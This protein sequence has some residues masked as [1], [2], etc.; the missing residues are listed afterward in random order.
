MTGLRREAM[1]RSVL[2]LMPE[3]PAVE[4]RYLFGTGPFL[5]LAREFHSNFVTHDERRYRFT[6]EWF[7]A[8]PRLAL[9]GPTLGW[10][11]QAIRSMTAALAPGYLERIELPL[12]LISAGQD[13]LI[14]SG[15]HGPVAA[16][17]G[18]GEVLAIAGAR[19]EVMMETDDLRALFWEA[20]DRL[21]KTVTGSMTVTQVLVIAGAFIVAGIAK[22]AIG[23]GLPPIALAL[24]SFAVPLEDALALMVVPSMATNI[25]QA[26]YGRGFLKL[27][28]R[29]W[30]MAVASV[31]AL[32]VRRGCLRPARLATGHGLGRRDP[33][34][35]TRRW[36][37][38]PGGRRC[39]A[40]PSAGPI[41]WSGWRAARSPASPASPPCRS[42]PTC[43]RSTSTG[44]TW[45]RRWASCSCSSSARSPWPW[46]SRAPSISPTSWARV[47]AIVPTFLGVWLGQ[48]AR[49]AGLARDLPHASSCSAC[50]SSACTWRSALL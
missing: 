29:F 25:W 39:R 48:K 41:R 11:R 4:E 28:R 38:P 27:L 9:G 22:G 47:A 49:Q 46:R 5:L 30:T 26:I 36:R 18:R 13:R 16:R 1:L 43:S 7:A 24:M 35:S 33:G 17:L 42:C 37:S 10:A 15:T 21:A 20:F 44:T 2:M 6:E 31:A 12:L 45:C 14:D 3:V 40:R 23:M 19:H 32:I 50:S 8:D 34:A